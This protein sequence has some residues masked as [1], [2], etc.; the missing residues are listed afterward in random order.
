[1]QHVAEE[2]VRALSLSLEMSKTELK[3][4]LLE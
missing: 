1:M 2:S 4:R 3:N